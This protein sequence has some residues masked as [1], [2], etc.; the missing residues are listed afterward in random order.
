MARINKV[1][2]ADPGVAFTLSFDVGDIPA[3]SKL[4]DITITATV[5]DN[6]ATGTPSFSVMTAFSNLTNPITDTTLVIIMPFGDSTWA[7]GHN[8][9]VSVTLH[10]VS[11]P[12]LNNLAI[13]TVGATS[14][15]GEF[16]YTVTTL[17]TFSL[18]QSLK[19][20]FGLK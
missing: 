1:Q 18:K 12:N 15:S 20:V 19:R 17:S 2:V 5:Q 10:S 4:T 7:A 11:V 14:Q 6:S 16:D 3:G 13:P 9:V 8:M